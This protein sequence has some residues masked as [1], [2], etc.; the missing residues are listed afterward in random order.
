MIILGITGFDNRHPGAALII[1]N[2]LTALHAEPGG[3]H[4]YD[5]VPALAIDQCLETVTGHVHSI[6]HIA[7]L[8][9]IPP[10]S[11]RIKT[12]A[13]RQ[14]SP[15]L[16]YKYLV[17]YHRRLERF[18]QQ[19]RRVLLDSGIEAGAAQWHRFSHTEAQA[20]SALNL[21]EQKPALVVSTSLQD[22]FHT[23]MMG[24]SDYL[25]FTPAITHLQPDSISAFYFSM[26]QFL[27]I[28]HES[29]IDALTRIA[30][31]GN[32]ETFDLSRLVQLNNDQIKINNDYINVSRRHSYRPSHG[33]AYFSD[34]LVD[35]L[36]EPLTSPSA[37]PP[38]HHYAAATEQ[39]YQ[40]CL[41]DL[42]DTQ[43]NDPM[44]AVTLA[45]AQCYN[46]PLQIY[47]KEKMPSVIIK[48]DNYSTSAFMPAQAAS[49]VAIKQ[50]QPVSVFQEET[51]DPTHIQ[52]ELEHHQ[53][54]FKKIGNLAR[55]SC[56]YLIKEQAIGWHLGPAEPTHR[57]EG[58]RMVA[59]LP[60]ACRH[61]PPPLRE[62]LDHRVCYI[63][64]TEDF[65]CQLATTPPDTTSSQIEP[66]AIKK[67]WQRLFKPL[68][69]KQRYLMIKCF[70]KA[71][72]RSHTD[73][74]LQQ[75][76]TY[77]TKAELPP[78]IV[79]TELRLNHHSTCHTPRDSL[80]AA[81]AMGLHALFIDQ[82]EVLL[83]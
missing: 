56:Q 12:L 53:A 24:S 68:L 9:D 25:A 35:W 4:F 64:T 21:C 60:T 34:Q 30:E 49:A 55:E 6:D 3:Q 75:L 52:R 50:G 80:H 69:Y 44:A 38:Y 19:L 66:V 22:R 57:T 70:K 33:N 40:R 16:M 81:R 10:I 31:T 14:W 37:S 18:E 77:L 47:L 72:A 78:A 42:I 29:D 61:L 71:A 83:S 41:A 27:G 59:F 7:I 2:V 67:K 20:L 65:A 13:R 58:R 11:T 28:T 46:L 51:N 26:G 32:S 17:Q 43:L 8:A 45:G 15:A 48:P 79:V 1:D 39:T 74:T 76:L 54:T 63:F 5:Q 62:Q 23:L 36:G 73:R 82:F